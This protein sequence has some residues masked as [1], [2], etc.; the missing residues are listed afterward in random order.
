M[1]SRKEFLA[2]LYE[3]LELRSGTLTGAESLADLATWDSLA[4]MSFIA[5]ASDSNGVTVAPRKIAGC[6]SVADLLQLAGSME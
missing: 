1:T 3:I 6:T 4:M 2:Y 5:L